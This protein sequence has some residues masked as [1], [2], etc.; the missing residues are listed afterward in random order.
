MQIV[1][2]HEVMDPTND[3]EITDLT[4][5]DDE[6]LD[7]TEEDDIVLLTPES[8]SPEAEREMVYLDEV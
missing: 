5:D 3:D 8:T 2:E 7:L 1:T 4:D 6:I